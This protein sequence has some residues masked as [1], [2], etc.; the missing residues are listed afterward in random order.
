MDCIPELRTPVM[1]GDVLAC[2]ANRQR[3]REFVL[4]TMTIITIALI[5]TLGMAVDGR[6]NL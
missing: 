5:G 6:L 2:V 4:I 1:K 3:K